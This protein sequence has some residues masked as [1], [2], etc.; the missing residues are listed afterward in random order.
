MVNEKYD[1]VVVGGGTAG[2]GAALTLV[3]VLI[4]AGVLH[5]RRP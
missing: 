2:L 1:V 3:A 4:G 5:R